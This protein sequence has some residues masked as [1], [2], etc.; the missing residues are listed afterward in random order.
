MTY[1][2]LKETGERQHRNHLDGTSFR[3]RHNSLILRHLTITSLHQL[4]MRLQSST[5]AISKKLE[6]GSMNVLPQKKKKSGEVF[7]R[8]V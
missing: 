1:V 8:W 4:E 7:M 6:N 3:P 2:C 5:S